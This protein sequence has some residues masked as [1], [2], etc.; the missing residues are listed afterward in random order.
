MLL[1]ILTVFGSSRQ[2]AVLMAGSRGYNNYRH[3]A[4]VFRIYNILSERG[5]NKSNLILLAYNDVVS[6]RMNPYKGKV[7]S[8]SD[9]KNVYP[10][11][12]AIDYSGKE[13]T[14]ENFM[15]VLLGDTHN[16]RALETT[17]EDDIF[18]Y[19]DDHGAPGLLCV[20]ANNG[21]EIYT[22]HI[23]HTLSEM[24]KKKK[25][26]NVF[27][28]IEACYSGSVARNITI[29]GVFVISAAGP[30]QSSYSAQ[31]DEDLGTFRTNE[32]TQHFMKFILE[33]PE[34]PILESV[35]YAAKSTSRSHVSAYGDFKVAQRPISSFLMKSQPVKVQNGEVG[36]EDNAVPNGIQTSQVFIEFIK[37]RLLKVQSDSE[38]SVLQDALE[39][40]QNRRE[41]STQTFMN[42]ARRL[43][44][45]GGNYGDKFVENIQYDCYR[46][47][48]EGFRVF[49]GEIDEHELS[50]L[51]I[52]TH[53][54][55][56][57]DKATLLNEIR[58]SCPSKK[59]RT[60]DLYF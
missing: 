35:N 28:V 4:D 52:F 14:A 10:G 2:W 34:S 42:I 16:G 37:R 11:E 58:A 25:F 20:P 9:H 48:I 33:N 18:I 15:R 7:F 43:D 1:F 27:F 56:N 47:A 26:R 13:A 41:I 31:W 59:W 38:R 6:H 49:C 17:E 5:F 36:D 22:D 32:F 8:T 12:H 54:C 40:E 24:K 53:L 45:N 30:T 29:P 46:A 23:A 55:Q 51:Q 44:P 19:Y 3:Q 57:T 21:P 50:K 39:R 60:E